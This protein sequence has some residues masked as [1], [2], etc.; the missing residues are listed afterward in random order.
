MQILVLIKQVPET[1]KVKM[2]PESGTMVRSGQET[3]INP[4]DLY[5]IEAALILKEKVGATVT[6][7]S[8]GPA[9]AERALREALA[10]GCDEAI[11]L[12]DTAFAG[13]DTWATSKVL[14]T[15]IRKVGEFDLIL[16]GERATD[17][18][19]GQVPPEVASQLELPVLTYVSRLD[20]RIAKGISRPVSLRAQRLTEEGYEVLCATLPCVASVVKEI[21]SPRLPTLRGKKAARIHPIVRWGAQD[22]GLAPGSIGLFGSPTRVVK[23]FYPK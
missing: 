18:D 9:D 3:I 17:G 7:L 22:L 20:S 13:S 11:L 1:D 14:A 4:L 16:T 5:A 21:A 12:T 8:M 6:V 2:D 10:M 23:I 15:A 19:T